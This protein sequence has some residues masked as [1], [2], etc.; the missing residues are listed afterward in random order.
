MPLGLFGTAEYDEVTFRTRPGDISLFFSDGIPDAQNGVGFGI[1][2]LKC[3]LESHAKGSADTI[4][5][6]VF[7]A[8]NEFVGHVEAFDDQ[9]VAVLKIKE[10]TKE[11]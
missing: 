3:V 1:K 8:V 4:L 2:R 6:A 5:D 9:A 11:K 10:T 7:A